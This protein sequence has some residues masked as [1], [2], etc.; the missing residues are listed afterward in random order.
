MK[1]KKI[2]KKDINA[3]LLYLFLLIPFFQV[4]YLTFTYPIFDKIYMFYLIT[5]V[6]IISL[7]VLIKKKYSSIINYVVIL[8]LIL[9]ISSIYNGISLNSCF[10][11]SL[12][13]IGL[14]LL[15]DYGTKTDKFNF[16]SALEFF[17]TLLLLINFITIIKYPTGMYMNDTGYIENWFL[18]YKNTHILYIIP[19]LLAS[20]LKSYCLDNKL[21]SRN[22]ALFILSFISTML[23]NNSTGLIGLAIISL[24][25]IMKNITSITKIF[26]IYNFIIAH[27][28]LFISIIILHAQELFSFL[29]VDILHKDLTFTGRVF[30]WEKA[31]RFIKIKPL[32]GYGNISFE[33]NKYIYSTHNMILGILH[34][35]GIIGLIIF[36]ILFFVVAKKLYKERN[37]KIC[38]MISFTLFAYLVMMLTEY[39]NFE[40]FIYI[41]VIASNI[42]YYIKEEGNG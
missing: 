13:V 5:S 9:F 32:L 16:F 41:L 21:H 2:L 1:D 28:V 7:M 36:C 8:M 30:I 40:Y 39:Y 34:K 33:Y 26:N 12:K 18:G 27:I 4:P 29:I 38:K 15:S 14:S 37:N 19:C 3:R 24:V 35:I 6:I 20:F 25:F 42:E 17:L 11:L 31:I 10:G 22:Y 23:V